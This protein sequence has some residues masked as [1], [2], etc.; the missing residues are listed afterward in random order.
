MAVG[1]MLF[2]DSEEYIKSLSP[3]SARIV[4][5]ICPECREERVRKYYKIQEAGHTFCKQC[6]R[7]K[8][9]YDEMI[10]KNFGNFLV[11]SYAESKIYNGK[12]ITRFNL[13][14]NCGN[15]FIADASRIKSGHTSSCGCSRKEGFMGENNPNYNPDLPL[16]ERNGKRGY[17]IERWALS[18][19]RRDNFT[20]QVCGSTE[21]PVAHHLNSYASAKDRRY[22]IKNGVTMCRDCHT[23]FHTNFLENYR[24]PCNEQD[25]EEYLLQV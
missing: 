19:K 10:G 1:M 17:P 6:I 7:R 21:K 8:N 3:M 18:V 23:D 15:N 16:E 14:C 9:N 5:A 22:D 20:C 25:F 2:G 13:L 11:V 12:K 24:V 4:T